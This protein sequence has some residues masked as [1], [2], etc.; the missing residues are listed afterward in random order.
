MIEWVLFYCSVFVCFLLLYVPG[1]AI[2]RA[3]RYGRTVALACAPIVTVIGYCVTGVVF[4]KAGVFAN[5]GLILLPTAAIAVL[6]V[7]G[8]CVRI[9]AQG[10]K[11]CA[12]IC[13]VRKL[14]AWVRGHKAALVIVLLYVF[15]GIVATQVVFVGSL[16]SPDSTTV[17][18]DDQSHL[19]SIRSFIER[20]NFSF[21]DVNRSYDV[22]GEKGGFYPAGWHILAALT[23]QLMGL[24]VSAGAAVALYVCCACMYPL[25]CWLFCTY[26]F[27]K[28]ERLQ[29]VGAFLT[30]VFAAFPWWFLFYG[31]LT[32]NLFSFCMVMA[33]VTCCLMALSREETRTARKRAAVLVFLGCIFAAFTSPNTFF[34]I[35]VFT[36]F[37]LMHQIW[38][39]PV[40]KTGDAPSLRRRLVR[41]AVFC[42]ALLVFLAVCYQSPVMWAVTHF[43]WPARVGLLEAVTNMLLQCTSFSVPAPLLG[44][45]VLGGVVA[46]VRRPSM[47]WLAYTFAA[48]FVMYV[49]DA[50][51][52]SRIKNYLTG[53]WYTDQ[54]RVSAMV[55]MISYPLAVLGVD[56]VCRFLAQRLK[57]LRGVVF[58]ACAAAVVAC[59]CMAP[60]FA[61]PNGE[62][63]LTPFGL[64]EGNINGTYSRS[65]T[66]ENALISQ[67]ERDFLDKVAAI[68][69]ED[70]VL[71]IPKDGSN[72][73][74]QLADVHVLHRSAYDGIPSEWDQRV[75]Q[76]SL[77]NIATDETVQRAADSVGAQYL[78]MLDY[79]H[80]PFHAY[81]GDYNGGNWL[82]YTRITPDTPGFELLLQ[83][84]DMYL[85]RILSAEER[86][87]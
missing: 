26:V 33:L 86:A 80:E 47:R 67:P 1:Y 8:A 38:F 87:E 34:T 13:D 43:K 53:F 2:L 46:A 42:F 35:I 66:D 62:V 4:Q 41:E 57:R 15:V 71:N 3:F 55:A 39:Y 68:T 30:P 6:C 7:C 76:R 74:Y 36:V 60:S 9:H 45:L 52:N 69:G 44:V 48:L 65:S 11:R 75:L 50:A 37:Y 56:G 51:T 25:S 31:R 64:V 40:R 81:W 20:G 79:G 77:N 61:L 14:G 85:Y 73:A 27:Q 12:G 70:L 49:I 21:L 29:A 16:S 54:F 84:D 23:T 5:A 18:F 63:V 59:V 24:S 19:G 58:P 32:S 83:E 72:F 17:C 82:G 22:P 78:L 28:S 10:G